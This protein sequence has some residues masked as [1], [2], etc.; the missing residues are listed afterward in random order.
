MFVFAPKNSLGSPLLQFRCIPAFEYLFL[1][2]T[3]YF[4]TNLILPFCLLIFGQVICTCE[5]LSIQLRKI[6]LTVAVNK[7]LSMTKEC[8]DRD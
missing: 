5:D 8:E 2:V 1:K 4:S 3:F 7:D 6:F